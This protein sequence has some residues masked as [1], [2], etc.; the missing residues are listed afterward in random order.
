MTELK[1]NKTKAKA[2]PS[3]EPEVPT[4]FESMNDRLLALVERAPLSIRDIAEE[5]DVPYWP[6]Y[7]W[8]AGKRAK[9]E[10]SLKLDY[11]ERLWEYF[12]GHKFN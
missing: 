5:S 8:S 11:A 4:G 9:K 6:L 1:D 2:E 10:Q 3:T 12:T 7:R